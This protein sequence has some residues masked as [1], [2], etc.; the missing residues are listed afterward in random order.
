VARGEKSRVYY[1]RT[2]RLAKIVLAGFVRD[3]PFIPFNRKYENESHPFFNKIYDIAKTID[4]E[5]VDSI[6]TCV[7]K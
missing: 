4:Q 6:D 1:Y 7:C 3:I 5:L 2:Q